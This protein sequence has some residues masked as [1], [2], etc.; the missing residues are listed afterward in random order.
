VWPA[1]ETAPVRDSQVAN[2][3]ALA[4][5]PDGRQIAIAKDD[6]GVRI[7]DAAT[8]KAVLPP[9]K[10]AGVR[11]RPHSIDALHPGRRPGHPRQPLRGEHL[12]RAPTAA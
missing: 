8:G 6:L 4:F 9:L 2:I 1:D 12:G 7:W 5:S 3:W 10:T 11:N